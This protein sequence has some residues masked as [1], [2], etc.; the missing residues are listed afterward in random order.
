[1]NA[2]A[3]F[4]GIVKGGLG[5]QLFQIASFRTIAKLAH[6]E[7]I[8][9]VE[10]FSVK[11]NADL[12]NFSSKVIFQNVPVQF[13]KNKFARK[14][15]TSVFQL[16]RLLSRRSLSRWLLEKFGIYME[17][18]I[19]LI[20]ASQKK[21]QRVRLVDGYFTDIGNKAICQPEIEEI[22][23]KLSSL[24][25]NSTLSDSVAIHL[26]LG[27]YRKLAPNLILSRDSIIKLIHD[28][29]MNKKKIYYF[30]DEPKEV[31]NFLGPPGDVEFS[32]DRGTNDPV[33]ALLRLSSHKILVC[34]HSTFS[35]WAGML[36]MRNGGTV[37]FP[38]VREG[39]NSELFVPESWIRF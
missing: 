16:L 32:I 3:Q 15:R 2:K 35:W 14:I 5:N 31:K 33:E 13:S 10:S 7:L 6:A 23:S 18:K 29:A 27:D 20:S 19:E 12:R 21:K 24:R 4:V 17:S 25:A 11:T 30:S 38:L 39:Q 28:S 26:R 1:M 36:V 9:N 37:Y 34:S 22:L 8:I